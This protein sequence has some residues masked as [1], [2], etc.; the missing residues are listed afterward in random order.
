MINGYQ[1]YLRTKG[2]M[3]RCN[4]AIKELL[5]NMYIEKASNGAELNLNLD[6]K[7]QLVYKLNLNIKQQVIHQNKYL[8]QL[9][10][11]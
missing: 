10:N 11:Y 9:V 4:R 6:L 1:S 8:I 3:K 7:N 5:K 2:L